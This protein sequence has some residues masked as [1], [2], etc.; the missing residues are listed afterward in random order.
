M[1]AFIY[2]YTVGGV[3]FLIGMYFA[4]R[5]G[6]IGLS[7]RGL[8]NLLISLGVLG[9]F[10]ILQ[11]SLQYA[12]MEEASAQPYVGGA[13]EILDGERRIR[14]TALDYGIVFAY[15]ALIL[16]I[17]TWFSRRQKTTR[18]FFFGGQKFAWW[19]IAFSLIATTVGSY[20]F[21]KYSE[22]GYSYGIGASQAYWNDWIWFPLLAFGWLPILYFSRIVSIPEYFGRRFDSKVRLWATIY[23]LVYLIGYVGVNLYT[24][25][26][27][28]NILL[29]WHIPL[30]AMLVAMVSATYVTLG[31]QT[32]VIMTDL[33]Q[34]VILLLVGILV[35]T[36]GAAYLGGFD[37]LWTNLP[38]DARLAFPNFNEAVD[39]PAIGIFWQDAFANTAVFY[40]LNQGIIMRFMAAK[41]LDESRKAATAMMVGLMF[42]GALVVASGGLVARAMT[43][44]GVL[45]EL[46]AREAFFVAAELLSHP[47]VF[48]LILAA[49]TAA[50]MSTVDTLI[51]AVSAV[52]VNDVYRPY[53][54]PKATDR[55]LLKAA[56]VTAVSVAVLGVIMVPVFMQFRTIYTAHAAFTAAVTPPMVVALMLSVF[57][58]RFTRAAALWTLVGGLIAIVF[59]MFV[60]A[61]ITPF[62]HGVPIGEAG[63]GFMGGMQQ[64]Q[65][66]RACFGGA[67]SVLIGVTV[68][69]L[70]KAEPVEKQRG[71]VW[72]TIGDAL[73]HY[74][75]SPGKEEKVTRALAIPSS[76]DEEPEPV[77]AHSL[78]MVH[79]SRGLADQIDAGEEDLIYVTDKRRWTGGLYSAHAVIG[80]VR[81]GDEP[82]VWM[83]PDT[84][85]LVVTPRRKQ[86]PVRVERLYG[87]VG[88]VDESAEELAKKDVS[89]SVA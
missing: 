79:V 47:G 74:K 19:L 32:S 14:G 83:G 53:V 39:F 87:T 55:Q 84:A 37:L 62:A 6:Y 88:S 31:G 67:V 65:F 21:V 29:G 73:R 4:Y 10:F 7:G 51:T 49:M 46:E 59:S 72:G 41:S 58:R 26:T 71:L 60:P 22:I 52:A 43:N 57:W 82:R 35:F 16:T 27:V 85:K 3:I 28:L 63:E 78:A 17:G 11:G 68:A 42:I 50:L 18:D 33:L 34:G 15:F 80:K 48:G 13:E 61:V 70:T 69:L 56:R 45:P 54:R 36:L 86:L 44:A 9:F 5:H 24:M 75:G 2:S 89:S 12:P 38:R 40:F 23:L 30:A 81:D 8:R 1:D 66:M 20:S 64:H 77:G 25:G 76:L